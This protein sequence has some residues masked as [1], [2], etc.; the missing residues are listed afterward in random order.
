MSRDAVN[1]LQMNR[2]AYQLSLNDD[3]VRTLKINRDSLQLSEQRPSYRSA[4][5]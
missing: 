4:N 3:E 1:A 2:D 5:E